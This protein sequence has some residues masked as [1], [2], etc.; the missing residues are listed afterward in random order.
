MTMGAKITFNN[1]TQQIKY[2]LTCDGDHGLFAPE[3]VTFYASGYVAARK[4]ANDAGWRRAENR[5]FGPCCPSS[6]ANRRARA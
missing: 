6:L 2:T 1:E 4:Q 3:P 5:H